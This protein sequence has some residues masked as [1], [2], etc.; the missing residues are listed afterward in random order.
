M[1]KYNVLLAALLTASCSV[2]EPLKQ[3]L[4]PEAKGV[5]AGNA[6]NAGATCKTIYR[7]KRTPVRQCQPVKQNK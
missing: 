1:K 6:G 2:T 3:P 5:H 7:H 4:Y